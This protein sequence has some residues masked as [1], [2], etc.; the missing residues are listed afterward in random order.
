MADCDAESSG[1]KSTE[2]LM[3]TDLYAWD[4]CAD[5]SLRLHVVAR[6]AIGSAGAVNLSIIDRFDVIICTDVVYNP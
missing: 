3:T 4:R 5:R 2:L 6:S 1:P